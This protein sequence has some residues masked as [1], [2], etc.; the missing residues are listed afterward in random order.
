MKPYSKKEEDFMKEYIEKLEQKNF[1]R[2]SKPRGRNQ[3]S[4]S[5]GTLFAYKKDGTPRPCIDY[6]PL[7]KAIV[8]DYYPIPRQ[9]KLQDRLQGAT[10]FTALDAR[11]AYHRIRMA[12]GE[13]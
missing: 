12:E 13:E 9:D 3:A 1:I 7:N 6:R 2:R 10:I 4:I 5:H 8:K 11:D